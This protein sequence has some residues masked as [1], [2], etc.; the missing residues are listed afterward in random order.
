MKKQKKVLKVVYINALLILLILLVFSC[1]VLA[2]SSI[3]GE[4]EISQDYLD[5][6][7][8]TDQEKENTIAPIMYKIEKNNTIVQNPF[9]ISRKLRGNYKTK[10]SLKEII[11]E[12]MIIKNQLNTNNCWAFATL[13]ALESHL[14]LQDYKKGNNL[15]IYDFSERHMDYATTSVFLDGKINKFG[16]NRNAGS[17][18]VDGMAIA[19]LTNGLGA[20]NEKDMEF[21]TNLDLIDISEIENKKIITQVNDIVTFPSY[22]GTEDTSKIKSEIKEHIM[23]YGA[24][25]TNINFT[26]NE[27]GAVYCNN[28]NL[29][30]INHTVAIIGWDDEYSIDNF[31]EGNR[32]V[33]C[34]AWIAKN[35]HGVESG[36]EGYIYISYEDVN[37]YKYL[38]GIQNAQTDITYENIYQYDELGGYL[39]YKV[40]DTSKLYLATEFNKKT[41]DIEYLTQI[42]I[43]SSET[44]T[45]KVYVNSEG[46]NK[47]IKNL[48]PVELKTGETITF[49]AGYHTIEFLNPIKIEK[50]FVVILEIQG[51]QTDYITTMVEVN[52]GEFF[53]DDKYVNAANHVYDTVTISDGKCFIATEEEI[54]NNNW[55]D[56][57]KLYETTDAK[58]PNFDTTI[59]AFTTSNILSDIEIIT[60]PNKTT[61]IVG[62]EFDATGLVVKANYT[63]G[64]SAVI[65]DYSIIDGDN[66]TLNQEEVTIV[67]QNKSVKQPIKVVKNKIETI[68]IKSEPT[69]TEY[70]AGEE[71]EP[72]GMI[73]VGVYTDESTKIIEDYNIQN[74]KLL[75]NGQTS[76]TIEYDGKTAIQNIMVKDNVIEKIEIKSNAKKL[77]Y[78]V[79][80]KFNPDGLIL[81]A[82]YKNGFEKE[83]TE[84]EYIIKDGEKLQKNQQIVT[85][86][87]EGLTIIQNIKV[88]E[89]KVVSIKVK[90]MPV[91]LEYIQGEKQLDLIGGELSI[92]YND[93]TEEEIS[94]T[95]NEIFATGFDSEK[96]GT[97]IITLEYQKNITQFEITIKEIDKPIN[98][99]FLSVKANVKNIQAYYFSD[100]NTKDYVI[101]NIE[102][103]NIIMAKENENIEYYYYLSPSS[104]ESN[105]SDW[106]K[107]NSMECQEEKLTFEI[108]SS[109]IP[110]YE[111][112]VR[113][114][115]VY[116]Y[117]K[118]VSIKNDMK[119][120]TIS[121]A[122]VLNINDMNI[123]EYI[124]GNKSSNINSEIKSDDTVSSSVFPNAGKN[125][126]AVSLICISVVLGIIVYLKYKEIEI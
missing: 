30:K 65:N 126:L 25:R 106:V 24:I 37:V 122:L 116:I 48:Q 40:N 56:A 32:P 60:E 90:T 101:L 2:V 97:Q 62:Q 7:E 76:V 59:K 98:S 89:K 13:A 42:S 94:M 86:E 83:V 12:N 19:Y 87:F 80:Q 115:K 46:T 61:Y 44:Y 58:I 28:A 41:E 3:N 45:C 113:E 66:L 57:S 34:G 55:R 99:D 79:G 22:L 8:L 15:V 95:S 117:I 11:S 73:V 14:A 100:K 23:E 38:I 21:Q 6:L 43:H 119:S 91:K 20:I 9:K 96:I 77:N 92:V 110:N 68:K 124:D 81:K 118:E 26:V 70:W 104:K 120:E 88:E 54:N 16:F 107:I 82:I 53:T 109:D 1:K 71:F 114:N 31:N 85:I 103:S 4:I 50:D 51:T 47:D 111:E 36:D 63:N 84:K 29:Y 121:D 69:K 123:E 75:M 18:G 52:F 78:I 74:G 108:N 35:S 27:N 105:I 39:K 17:K 72:E 10:F 112:I 64:E 67:Y 102:L 5:Y 125:I 49:D 93:E 33:N